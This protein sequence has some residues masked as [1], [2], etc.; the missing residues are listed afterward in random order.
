MWSQSQ[1]SS[2]GLGG[3]SRFESVVESLPRSVIEHEKSILKAF[4]ALFG[5][6]DTHRGDKIESSLH[7]GMVT[8]A[9]HTL[10]GVEE[11]EGMPATITILREPISGPDDVFVNI[12]MRCFSSMQVTFKS[13]CRVS[14]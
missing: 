7:T 1:A 2:I 13:A 4:A 3:T 11:K 8:V 10:S 6:A 9:T 14:P 5:L 12:F